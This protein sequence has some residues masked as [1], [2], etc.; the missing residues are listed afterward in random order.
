MCGWVGVHLILLTS[1]KDSSRPIHSLALIEIIC[2]AVNTGREVYVL[3]CLDMDM[4]VAHDVSEPVRPS[5]SLGSLCSAAS[6]MCVTE[7]GIGNTT[8]SSQTI[9]GLVL[10][11]SLSVKHLLDHNRSHTANKCAGCYSHILSLHKLYPKHMK[12]QI[13]IYRSLK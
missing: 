1:S 12:Q 7:I 11:P 4:M 6:G 2:A 5:L 8:V 9:F 13:N 3:L 10:L